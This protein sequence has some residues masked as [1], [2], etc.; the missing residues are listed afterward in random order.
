VHVYVTGPDGKTKG[1]PFTANGTRPDV[2]A[3]FSLP[4]NHGFQNSIPIT[5]SGRY[6]VCAYGISVSPL[7]AGNTLLGC[8]DVVAQPAAP[9]RGYLDTARLSGTSTSKSI[10]A[11]GWAMDPGFTSQSVPVRVTVKSPDASSKSYSAFASLARPDVNRA[12]GVTGNH[13]YRAAIAIKARGKY[14]VCVSSAGAGVLRTGVSALG[15]QSLTY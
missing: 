10:V 2:N 13:G 1:Y 8:R 7:S 15:C 4:G 5:L 14:T 12:L 11:T 3:A 9:V 6:H